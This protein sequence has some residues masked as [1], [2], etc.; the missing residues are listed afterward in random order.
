MLPVERVDTRDSDNSA[1]AGSAGTTSPSRRLVG[2]SFVCTI[3]GDAAWIVRQSRPS[4]VESANSQAEVDWDCVGV[5]ACSR[6]QDVEEQEPFVAIGSL[7]D[8]AISF[9]QSRHSVPSGQMQLGRTPPEITV[10]NI[11]PH[12]MTMR[13]DCGTRN[14]TSFFS[15]QFIPPFGCGSHGKVTPVVNE[16][17][18][19]FWHSLI[20]SRRLESGWRFVKPEISG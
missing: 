2:S 15:W 16:K 6:Q 8:A 9:G 17:L 5:E 1:C 12:V 11:S 20:F 4:H 14:I 10:R 13:G 19:Q 18:G 3:T 7:A